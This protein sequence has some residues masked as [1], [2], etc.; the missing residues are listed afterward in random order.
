MHVTLIEF[1]LLLAVAGVCGAIGQSIAGL[2]K[3]GCI[4]A[5][6]VGFVGALLGAAIS[7]WLHLP[8][9]LSVSVGRVS[10]PIVWSI[11]GSALFVAVLGFLQRRSD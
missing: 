9:V 3:G 1:L 11:A 7:R 10:F 5:I 6:A 2:S 4:G 8:D